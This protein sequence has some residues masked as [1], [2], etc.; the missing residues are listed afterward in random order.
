MGEIGKTYSLRVKS[1]N[2]TLTAVTTIPGLVNFD[3]LFVIPH[4]NIENDTLVRLKGHLND[5]LNWEIII[6]I[7]LKQIAAHG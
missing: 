1:G 7:L 3:S 6:G 4:P 2:T 5:R